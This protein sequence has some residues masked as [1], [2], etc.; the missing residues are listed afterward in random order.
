[1]KDGDN[2]VDYLTS[3]PETSDDSD[4][5]SEESDTQLQPPSDPE[6]DPI[7]AV[8]VSYVEQP[9]LPPRPKPEWWAE[10]LDHLE[11]AILSR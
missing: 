5:I 1:M 2:L 11:G 10:A 7:A 8:R 4:S 6:D 9:H 3:E